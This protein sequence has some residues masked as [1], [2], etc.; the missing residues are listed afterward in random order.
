MREL[1]FLLDRVRARAPLTLVVTN[2]VTIGDGANALLAIGPAPVMSADPG[3][4]RELA[5]L[6]SATVLNIGTI[7]AAQLEVLLAA[8]RGARASG[9][10][11][12]LD[13]VGAG[14][15][16][17][18]RAAVEELLREAP[19]DIIRGNWSEI[20]AL[21]GLGGVQ[22]GVDSAGGADLSAVAALARELAERQGAVVAVTGA[23][24]VVA[25]RGRTWLIEGGSPLLTRLT[26]TGC[27]L[28]AM[29]G[30][31][32][33]AADGDLALATL[34]ALAHLTLAGER[35]AGGEADRPPMESETGP[36]LGSFKVSLFDCLARLSPE[37]LA[38]E[39][40]VTEK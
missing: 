11:V 18:R 16:A 13:P 17:I 20:Q 27:L 15:T 30:A 19:P 22:R 25:A 5:T 39:A 8:G 35:A 14:A 1:K 10:P 2:H 38:R 40:R 36:L 32:A 33:S 12:V 24:D 26:G 34:G 4:A 31:Y 3:D 37:D 6:A 23:V 7:C 21:A 29:T 28:S 9:R